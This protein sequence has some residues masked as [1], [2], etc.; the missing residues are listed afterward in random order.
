MIFCLVLSELS[1]PYIGA[2]CYLYPVG[3]LLG[4]IMVWQVLV[5]APKGGAYCLPGLYITVSAAQQGL[6]SHV[7]RTNTVT[8]EVQKVAKATLT[9][10]MR[11]LQVRHIAR[12]N[13][14][15][16]PAQLRDDIWH[17]AESNLF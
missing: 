15:G 1:I 2:R 11:H 13:R 7:A 14:L 6:A 12:C 10:A 9:S 4:N 16:L 3:Q 5:S 8:A 17:T